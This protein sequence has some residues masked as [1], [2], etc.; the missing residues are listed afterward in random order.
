M[1]KDI[2]KK[3]DELEETVKCLL[4]K[5]EKQEIITKRYEMLFDII[6][7]EDRDEEDIK[8]DHLKYYGIMA[9]NLDAKEA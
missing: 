6:F 5:T 3:I 8:L 1:I 2:Q 9:G 4:Q 7:A